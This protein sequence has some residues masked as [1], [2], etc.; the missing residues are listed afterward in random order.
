MITA[1]CGLCCD[2]MGKSFVTS[3][4]WGYFTFV[5]CFSYHSAVVP[6]SLV[7]GP[8]FMVIIALAEMKLRARPW[9]GSG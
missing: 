1:E 9:I 6:A 4:A 5:R 3:I 2:E 8:D 7:S